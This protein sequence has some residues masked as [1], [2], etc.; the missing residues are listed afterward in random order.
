MVP[1]R[2]VPISFAYA[3]LAGLL[4]SAWSGSAQVGPSNTSSGRSSGRGPDPLSDAAPSAGQG[5]SGASA[6]SNPTL[7]DGGVD[8][9][10][11]PVPALARVCPDG[12]A[13]TGVY[14]AKGNACVLEFACPLP[15]EVDASGTPTPPGPPV[16]GGFALS[17]APVGDAGPSA[18]GP[19]G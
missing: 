9:S 12:T 7:V 10:A 8:C 13:A 19:C 2:R 16:D 1:T 11:I 6:G 18:P 17:P 15:V 3:L 4:A 14:I 5:S